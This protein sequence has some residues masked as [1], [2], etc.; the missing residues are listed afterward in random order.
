LQCRN[1]WWAKLLQK[2]TAMM[3]LGMNLFSKVIA[4]KR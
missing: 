1:Q 2:V 4:L 3:R